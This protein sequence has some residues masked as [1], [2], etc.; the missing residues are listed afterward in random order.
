[1]PGKIKIAPPPTSETTPSAEGKAVMVIVPG[2]VL[3]SMDSHEIKTDLACTANGLV[4][5]ATITR[6]A[7]YHGA[8]IKNVD[9]RPRIEMTV[10]LRKPEVM[11]EAIWKMRLTNGD[12][13]AHTQTP[14][15]PEQ[16]YPITMTATVR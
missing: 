11:L 15:Y 8:V 12:W 6:S 16:T 13:V 5:T 10:I 1:M 9:W 7:D 14:G 4:L 2:P 3:G